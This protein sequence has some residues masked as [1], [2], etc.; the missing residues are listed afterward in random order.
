[1]RTPAA[2]HPVRAC[3]ACGELIPLRARSTRTLCRVCVARKAQA[4][5]LVRLAVNSRI[6]RHRPKREGA[7]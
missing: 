3:L 6:N 7:G 4:D 1:M 2:A 5:L